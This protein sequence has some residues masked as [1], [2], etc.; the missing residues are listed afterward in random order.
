MIEFPSQDEGTVNEGDRETACKGKW[1]GWKET[2]GKEEM[3]GR[4]REEKGWQ[5][6]YMMTFSLQTWGR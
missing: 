1:M 3:T 6:V 5:I 2:R 4:D